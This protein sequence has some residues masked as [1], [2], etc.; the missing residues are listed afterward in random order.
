MSPAMLLDPLN[1]AITINIG[2][3]APRDYVVDSLLCAGKTAILAGFGGVSKTQ[4]ALQLSV[5]VALGGSFVNNAVKA[6]RVMAICGEEDRSE[7]GRRL[8]AIAKHRGLN[9]AQ[10]QA[11]EANIL[12]YPLVGDDTRLTAMSEKG[13]AETPFAQAIIDRAKATSDVRLIVLDHMGL[14][15]GGDFNKREDAALTMRVTNHIAERTGAAVLA[16]AHTP[17]SANDKEESDASMVAGST[18]FVDQARAALVMATMRPDEAKRLGISATARKDYVSLVVAKNNYGPTGDVYWFKRVPVDG[19]AFLEQVNL[20][21]Q[22]AAFKAAA[23]LE[24]SVIAVVAVHPGQF[25]KTNLRDSQSGKNG[26]FKASKATL[27][28]V[29]ETLIATGQLVNRPPTSAER[30]TYGHSARVTHVLDVPQLSG[31][32]NA[33]QP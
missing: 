4:L 14:H 13:L 30:S 17:K 16:L 18:A 31:G 24:A 22:G 23:N 33:A 7:I 32:A 19:T 15:H 8:S 10:I 5:D 11:I 26:R 25:S 12:A 9:P 6:G 27:A 20:S 2:P 21:A 3:P 28:G 29:I 1:G